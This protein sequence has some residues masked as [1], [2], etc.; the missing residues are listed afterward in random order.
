MKNPATIALVFSSALLTGCPTTEGPNPYQSEQ[1]RYPVGPQTYTTTRGNPC[2]EGFREANRAVNQELRYQQRHERYY[3]NNGRTGNPATDA[4]T[5]FTSGL[6]QGLVNSTQATVQ[7][8]VCVPQQ[9]Y[10]VQEIR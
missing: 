9:S 7:E 2:A 6:V 8:T 4:V 5:A 3:R 1:H 10:P